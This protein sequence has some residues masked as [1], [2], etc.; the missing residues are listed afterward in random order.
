M[1][2]FE[3]TGMIVLGVIAAM[4]A[5]IVFVALCAAFGMAWS[6]ASDWWSDFRYRRSI[7]HLPKRG[8]P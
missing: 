8:R 1:P 6:I 3:F 4:I 2:V 7:R 5:F